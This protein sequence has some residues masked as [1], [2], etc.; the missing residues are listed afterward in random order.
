MRPGPT[1]RSAADGVYIP[2]VIIGFPFEPRLDEGIMMVSDGLAGFQAY[3]VRE[4][5]FD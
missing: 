3:R 1:V 2:L 5:F 4:V